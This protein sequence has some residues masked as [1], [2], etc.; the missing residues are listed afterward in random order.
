M[1]DSPLAFGL[2]GPIDLTPEA[3]ADPLA[4]ALESCSSALVFS[5]RDAG[6]SRD[7]AWLYGILVGWCEPDELCCNCNPD[8]TL[9]EGSCVLYSLAKDHGWD[10]ATVNRLVRLRAAVHDYQAQ[11]EET[12]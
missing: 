8:D 7:T 3:G 10:N 12:A 1:P 5:P 11:I 9:S 6:A 4:D 2:N